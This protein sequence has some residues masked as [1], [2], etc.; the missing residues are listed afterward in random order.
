MLYIIY[1]PGIFLLDL[2]VISLVTIIHDKVTATET[3]SILIFELP[4]ESAGAP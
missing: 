1:I 3:W 2:F 4:A